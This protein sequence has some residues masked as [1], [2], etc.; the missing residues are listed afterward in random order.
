LK[1]PGG[2]TYNTAARIRGVEGK[3]G[4]FR[5]QQEHKTFIGIKNPA[6][7]T[8]TIAPNLGS[9]ISGL[10]TAYGM[11]PPRTKAS[12]SGS[13]AKRKLNYRFNSAPGRSVAIYE[14]GSGVYSKIVASKHS[15]VIAFRPAVGI[16]GRRDIVA[17]VSQT[18]LITSTDVVG[19]YTYAP[20]RLARPFV[21]VRKRGAT[22][23]ASWRGVKGATGYGVTLTTSAG[24][25]RFVVV[26][27]RSARFRAVGRSRKFTVAVS[28]RGAD[29]AFGPS[30]RASGH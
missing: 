28:G 14:R 22:V 27:G 25:R 18:G 4:F 5:S 16:K 3:F 10:K 23:S 12:V 26:K 17:V 19:R 1:A 30:G 9:G 7:G 11:L 2:R 13:G 20:P 21:K 29:Q 6:A 8:W 15:S 24:E